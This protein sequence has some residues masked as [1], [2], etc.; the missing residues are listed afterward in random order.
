METIKNKGNKKIKDNEK[1]LLLLQFLLEISF[2]F[3]VDSICHRQKFKNK[4]IHQ[5]YHEYKKF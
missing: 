4:L 1:L 2:K 5:I 3:V